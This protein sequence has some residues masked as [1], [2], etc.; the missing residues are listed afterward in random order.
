MGNPGTLFMP[1]QA[2]YYPFVTWI[3]D[4][5]P[6]GTYGW[7]M[8]MESVTA[9][10]S[11]DGSGHLPWYPGQGTEGAEGPTDPSTGYYPFPTT[12]PELGYPMEAEEDTDF[13]EFTLDEPSLVTISTNPWTTDPL[14]ADSDFGWSLY[15]EEFSPGCGTGT[16]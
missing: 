15:L 6:T 14:E 2:Y 13:Y 5:V 4:D 8:L 9:W 10:P 7:S 3:P 12:D 16:G 1:G 11:V